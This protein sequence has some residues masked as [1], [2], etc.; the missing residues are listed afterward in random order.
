MRD[1]PGKGI[2]KPIQ[3]SSDSPV[4]VNRAFT[5]FLGID[6]EDIK[7]INR[8]RDILAQDGE[9]FAKVFYDYLLSHPL[10][11]EIL[12]RYQESGGEIS[13]LV[14][15]QL[16]HLCTLLSGDTSD[17]SAAQLARIGQIHFQFGIQPVWVMGAYL[18]YWNHLSNQAAKGNIT[19][20]ELL[21]GGVAKLLFR[22]MGLMLEGYWDAAT[23][24]L[25]QEKK[26]I[27]SLQEQIT[28][29]LSNLPQIL[30]SVDVVANNLLYVSPNT[31]DVCQVEVEL[32]I[33]CMKWT[34]PEDRETVE[35]AWRH[36][37]TGSHIEVESRVHA[38]GSSPRWFRRVFHPYVDKEGRVVR[39]D[40][41]MEDATESKRAV[42][43]LHLLATTDS[44]TGLHNRALFH[45][46]L[47][48]AISAVCRESNFQVV[49][50][51]MDLDH[52]KEINDTL[53][54]PVG[55][56]ILREVA[57]R[58]KQAL[59]DSDTL[60]RLG[61]DEFAVLLPRTTRGHQVP[62]MAAKKLLECFKKPFIHEGQELYL[63]AGIG[64][65]ISPEHGEDVDTLMSRADIA[66]YGAK[67]RD[68]GFAFYDAATDSHT[69]QRLHLYAELRRGLENKEFILHYQPQVETLDYGIVGIEALVRW[70]H[71]RRGLILP[72]QFIPTAERTGLINPLTEWVMGEALRQCVRQRQQGFPIRVAV[73]IAGR[74]LQQ[75][76]LVDMITD[77]IN[78]AQA[79]SDCLEIE[80]TENV[81]ISDIERGSHILEQLSKMG[82][83]I[84]ID[85]YGTG[86]SS[87]AYLRKLPLHKLKIDK[88]F[89]QHMINDENDAII[90]RSTID[91]AHNLGYKI[92]AEGV[93]DK[94]TFDLLALLGCN[95]A[96]G[97]YIAQPLTATELT[98]WL[99]TNKNPK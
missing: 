51:L 53:G 66:M 96:Q 27:V 76:R 6:T 65:V 60:A 94:E 15:K 79:T 81:L 56:E 85:D 26:A 41:L 34:I 12:Q 97:N 32:P 73:N 18:L 44:L 88:S 47:T 43:R 54:H 31:R 21:M 49:L 39:I 80:I 14:K 33:P 57:R 74:S 1:E 37:L 46:R 25:E 11:C 90:V 93:E 68:G 87:L 75:L 13:Q 3:A 92:V 64:I 36:A 55:D 45:D 42:E 82:V 20:K 98:S 78:D 28:S 29:L 7:R 48:Q 19:D 84:S 91:L 71:P 9:N 77:I 89:V 24:A 83:T 61:G 62:E 38:P 30:W 23:T 8:H 5:Q 50:M 69:P 63:G 58:L 2:L 86:Q 40:G 67:H 70:N 59:R 16:Q 72:D 99:Q 4:M 35:Q 22:D 52:F 10:T 17:E 95:Y